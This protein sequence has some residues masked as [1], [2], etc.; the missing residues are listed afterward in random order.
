[1]FVYTFVDSS[2][3]AMNRELLCIVQ[4]RAD[5]APSH[6]DASVGDLLKAKPKFQCID[7]NKSYAS[8]KSLQVGSLPIRNRTSTNSFSSA[9]SAASVMRAK[10]NSSPMDKS[11]PIRSRPYGHAPAAANSAEQ[12]LP[13]MRVPGITSHEYL[14]NIAISA[15]STIRAGGR[16]MNA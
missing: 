9:I 15:T 4:G 1:M 11:E 14:T 12:S 13:W 8:K 5:A 7:C 6:D 16:A 10:A 2:L 3:S